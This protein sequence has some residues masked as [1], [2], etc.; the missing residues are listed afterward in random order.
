MILSPSI[1][2]V[3]ASFLLVLIIFLGAC[4]RP[5]DTARLPADP[6]MAQNVWDRFTVAANRAENLASPFHITATLHYSGKEDS[7]RVTTYFWGNG[8]KSDPFPLRLDILMGPGSVIAQTREEIRGI[9]IYVPRDEAVYHSSGRG[10]VSLGVPLPFSLADLASLLTARF[11]GVFAP[12]H[13]ML[14]ETAPAA[15]QGQNGN[16]IYA[17]DGGSLPGLWTLSPEGLPVAWEEEGDSGWTL[18]ID[19]WPD[20]TRTTPRKLYIRH[21][22]GGEATLIVR[23]LNHPKQDFVPQQLEMAVPP[24]T[25][26]AHLADTR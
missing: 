13:E 19:Y 6:V 14:P 26:L 15:T 17:I 18:A 12:D 7:Q 8:H 3:R 24:N 25:R 2:S 11:T 21:P 1:R 9:F 23:E 4:V 5:T 20:S 10:L 22:E 16:I